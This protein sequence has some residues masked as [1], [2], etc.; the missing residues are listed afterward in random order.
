MATAD[1]L[2]ILLIHNHWATHQLFDACDGLTNEQFHQKFEIGEGSLH[3]NITHIIGAMRSWGDLLAGRELRGRPEGSNHSI[4]ELK[5]M[6]NDASADF[7]KSAH[8]H[9][10]AETVTRER[11]GK[12]YTFTRGAVA[13]HVMTHGMHHRAQCLNMLRH[14]GVEKLPQSSV[15][16]WTLVDG[17]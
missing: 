8:A 4:A 10:V 13:T 7:S 14:L 2:D 9:P 12:I 1:P 11:G 16:E 5:A 17:H 3:N 6:L 15:A